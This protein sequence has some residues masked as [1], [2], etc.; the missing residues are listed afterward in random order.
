[1]KSQFGSY[2][3]QVDETAE[4]VIIKKALLADSIGINDLGTA[5]ATASATGV[6]GTIVVT[7]DYLYVCTATDTWKRVALA[8]W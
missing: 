1:M 3:S 8:T 7:A 6:K 2:A 5:P 4:A